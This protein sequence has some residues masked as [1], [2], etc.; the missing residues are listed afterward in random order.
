MNSKQSLQRDLE[1]IKKAMCQKPEE[2]GQYELLENLKE[3]DRLL[4]LV[5]FEDQRIIVKQVLTEYSENR[6]CT[7]V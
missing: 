7:T 3:Y 2:T 5:S 4:H 1:I 6:L